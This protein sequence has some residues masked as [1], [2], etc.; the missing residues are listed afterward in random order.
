[1]TAIHK[2]LIGIDLDGK[3]AKLVKVGKD[4]SVTSFAF[5]EIPE[6]VI[7]SGKIESKQ[8]LT[9]TLKSAKKS[10][11]TSFNKCALCITCPDVVIRHIFIPIMDEAYIP[12]SIAMELSGFLPVSPDR[13]AIDYVITDR[14]VT[15]E[16]KQYA[17]TVFA[18]P[19]EIIE[20]YASCIINAGFNLQYIDVMEN[21][22]EKLHNSFIA[23]NL[24]TIKNFAFLHI[25][26]LKTSVSIYNNSKLLLNK[27]IGNG[28]NK[29]CVEISEK[30]GKP[31]EAVKQIIYNNDI[32]SND[33]AYYKE[34]TIIEKYIGEVSV[35]TSR[36]ID[37][38]KSRNKQD[39][40]EVIYL[41][42][43]FSHINDISAH[44]EESLGIP[45]KIISDYMDTFF[46]NPPKKKTGVDYTNAIAVTIREE[47]N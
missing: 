37:Y 31:P 38:Y 10:L 34:K 1:M 26:I 9:E 18:V 12:N 3:N 14:I 45:V 7:V 15:E 27:N 47:K 43:A 29:V 2:N 16:S 4:G 21:A 25:D 24:T 32:L 44:I 6:G 39:P 22:F 19:N 20:S 46:I 30:T 36:F 23:R 35:E 40:L 28:A 8:M 33:D 17:L 41:S 5:A 42:G 11:E 13:Y